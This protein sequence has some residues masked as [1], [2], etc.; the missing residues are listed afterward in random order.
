MAGARV[1]CGSAG[2]DAGVGVGVSASVAV[3]MIGAEQVIRDAEERAQVLGFRP[4]KEILY[5]RLL[6]YH[7]QLDAESESLLKKIRTNLG[8][9]VVLRELKPG[10][11]VWTARL[12]KYIKLYGLKFT[13]E[14]HIELI[15]LVYELI[16]IPDLEPLKLHKFCT[17]LILLT[18]R[19][20]LISPE[21][22]T[23]PWKPL[24]DLGRRIFAKCASTLGMYHYISSLETTYSVM[25][26]YVKIYFP[27]SATLEILDELLP[28]FVPTHNANQEVIQSLVFLLPYQ[29]PPSQLNQG[30]NVW[31]DDFMTL[32]QV[33]HNSP[34][35]EAD[36]MALIASVAY[37]NIGY[38]DFESYLSLMFTRFLRSFNL[39]VF[40][41]KTQ[42]HKQQN[43]DI[44][45]M[46]MWIVAVLGPQST[47]QT[48][49]DNFMTTVTTYVHSANAGK[50]SA[51]LRDLLKKL[52]TQFV[53]RV[54]RE[55][56]NY[57]KTWE[58]STPDSYKLTDDDITRFVECMLDV[59]LQ[60]VFSR[61]GI[62]DTCTALQQLALL[63]PS[64]VIPPIIDK[65]WCNLDSLTEP[66]KLTCSM[67]C[68]VAVARPLVSGFTNGYPEGPTHIIPLLLSCLPGLDPNDFKKTI[69]TFHFISV[70]CNMV[71]LVDCSG[72]SEYWPDL[73][74]EEQSVCAATAQFEDFV[75]Q[76]F[77]RVFILIES[78]SMEHTRM[79]QKEA[80][81]VRSK[82]ESTSEGALASASIA[83][84]GQTSTKIFK[85]ALR[86]F[87]EFV[88]ER[89][90][91]T[92]VAGQTA[93]TLCRAFSRVNAFETFKLF[94][95]HLCDSINN[96][97]GDNQEIFK[98]ESLDKKLLFNLL[99]LS[100]V[101]ERN[102]ID[103][104]PYLA[105]IMDVL[106][107]TLKLISKEGYTFAC[108]TLRNVIMCL[109]NLYPE[110][111]RSSDKDYDAHVKDFLAIREWGKP[112]NI[113]N[114]N[115]KW[116]VPNQDEIDGVQTL[117]H[118]YLPQELELL[119]KY[120][121]ES[122][123]LTK[124][125]LN[126]SLS[127]IKALMYANPLMPPWDVEPLNLVESAVP[128]DN[129]IL[130]TGVTGSVSMPDGGNVRKVITVVMRKLQNKI[131]NSE[132]TRSLCK[133][134]SIWEML[135]V[136]TNYSSSH[137][138]TH[139]KVYNG[140]KRALEDRLAGRP[141]HL[142]SLL[143]DRAMLQH[144]FRVQAISGPLTAAQAENMLSLFTLATSLYSEVR[145][146][147]QCRLNWIISN[148]AYS[149]KVVLPH[150]IESLK[151][152]PENEHERLKG[153]LYCL[154]GPK[155]TPIIAKHDWKVI[156]ELWP[157]VLH[158]TPS[159]KPSVIRLLDSIIR[160]IILHFPTI[161]IR[162]KWSDACVEKGKALLSEA[163][164][165]DP[166]FLEQLEKCDEEVEKVG[167]QNVKLHNELLDIL[168]EGA[169]STSLH[170]RHSLM[171][172]TLVPAMVHLDVPYPPNTIKLVLKSLIHDSILVRKM[173]L[174]LMVFILK[175]R[176]RVHKKVHIETCTII[177]GVSETMN[178]KCIPGFRC[179]NRWL[180]YD[181]DKV[182]TK[183]EWDSKSY[184]HSLESYGFFYWPKTIKMYAPPAE[185]PEYNL[186]PQDLDDSEK[187]IYDFFTD[188]SNVDKLINYLSMEEKKGKDKFSTF[189]FLMFK[190]IFINYGDAFL[191]LFVEH[192]KRLVADK[193]EAYQRCAA[194]I[195]AGLIKGTKHWSFAKM[196]NVKK[197]LTPIIKV[198]LENMTSETFT[199][200]GL[201]FATA[202]ENV[203][204]SRTGWILKILEDSISEDTSSAVLCCR[205]F[206][207]Q[208]IILQHPWRV[209]KYS[210]TLLRK[211]RNA[212]MLSHPYQNVRDRIAS[213]MSVIFEMDMVFPGGTQKVAP[214]IAAMIE[215]ISPQLNM[216]L[217]EGMKG[218]SVNHSVLPALSFP[219]DVDNF[220]TRP[221]TSADHQNNHS[222]N[223]SMEKLKF[224]I[225]DSISKSGIE[226]NNLNLNAI[227][228]FV[229]EYKKSSMSQ[230]DAPKDL[231]NG[232]NSP[233]D[234]MEPAASFLEDLKR[235]SVLA[236]FL[237][238]KLS[239][240]LEDPIKPEEIVEPEKPLKQ[241]TEYEINVRLFKTITKWITTTMS[242][243][244]YGI[245]DSFYALFPVACA[246]GSREGD[247]ELYRLCA[248]FLSTLAESLHNIDILNLAITSVDKVCQSPSWGARASCLSFLQ[249]LVFHNMALVVN[250]G[251][252]LSEIRR[253]T[254][255]LMNDPY[256][257]VRESAAV[258]LAGLL[259]CGVLTDIPQLLDHFKSLCKGGKV[260][261][262]P[263]R[264]E[265]LARRH[266][267]VLGLCAFVAAQPY[268][269]PAYLPEIF[270]LLGR[271][272]NDP[273]PI[274]ATIRKTLGD[275][276]RTHHD[277][278]QTHKLKF[279]EDE[280]ALLSDLTV[281]PSYYA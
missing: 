116:H 191:D 267:G 163:E 74:E 103:L 181:T 262:G 72:A 11:A 124:E 5:N 127:I 233:M 171:C 40:Y 205:L 179:D 15:H 136:L 192:L 45:G 248:A 257:E 151:V 260:K 261:K 255:Q 174:K 143:A 104:L 65:M 221:T 81:P 31:L 275:F 19:Y 32:W 75:L 93:S 188:K 244:P 235:D 229:Q 24:Y 73:T 223:T 62:S 265:E 161:T 96:L 269:V 152:N 58:T 36:L 240:V 258:M 117:L 128:W 125:E 245:R 1:S 106:D 138:E 118:R 112:G 121:D 243:N 2:A 90:L 123:T 16:I 144:E 76:Y 78:S 141:G 276:K 60:A 139:L 271:H 194:E 29:M 4:Q 170:W 140:V 115:L 12:I 259:H 22:L 109:C 48:F 134:V 102:G 250:N 105:Q 182:Y 94:I 42:N 199:D 147:S 253:L 17:L 247:E 215:D 37:H 148:F 189:K 165:S 95:P 175:Q 211:F 126:R 52:P 38:L 241:E 98:E 217:V 212:G 39:P 89:I 113:W 122:V 97:V 184:S 214:S 99:L 166:K 67:Q 49:L 281:P 119:N 218:V 20:H 222:N 273:L 264:A 206:M 28:N 200:W 209:A 61:T 230:N 142:R 278:W 201:C 225:Q 280:L 129:F 176:K 249:S 180:Q 110:K 56:T 86:K 14:C 66:H 183:E 77:E 145:T 35:W 187:E 226:K 27:I 101:V 6:P 71:P 154:L 156:R 268:T 224:A 202:F 43:I 220:D 82:L 100:Q 54:H 21:E 279:T 44:S 266:C 239:T 146:L 33:C 274:P 232:L 251:S 178:R 195:I 252:I 160:S 208:V 132:D 236:E 130:T 133:L 135:T 246:L 168:V 173:S 25:L 185:Q 10:A 84:L 53:Q 216:L 87:K 227:H 41:K 85:I 114:C 3:A 137:F 83:V 197:V 263:Q 158:S 234:G 68:L 131:L 57:K 237:E 172:L 164:L 92:N 242:R 186:L 79:E 120:I 46:A 34:P 203:D 167:N 80:E 270:S 150:L 162:L 231:D 196:R 149:F 69:V 256:P 23:L 155:Q 272:L 277:D 213:V 13:K 63:K 107:K 30:V 169:E 50:W 228:K 207:L 238:G 91:E 190:G 7:Q 70:L 111:C 157:A 55:R 219:V 204:I 18:K 59:T 8:R 47:A 177:E 26:Q 51:K 198:V 9:A 193:Q 254:L 88:T 64:M 108:T 153:A 159:E 210:H